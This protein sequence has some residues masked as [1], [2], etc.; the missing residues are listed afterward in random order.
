MSPMP[1]NSHATSRVLVA[2]YG[3][4]IAAAAFAVAVVV[5]IHRLH[6]TLGE[7]LD[8]VELEYRETQK[9]TTLALHVQRFAQESAEA[10]V[11]STDI[12]DRL[13]QAQA[14][15][16]VLRDIVQK[17]EDAVRT[18][19]DEQAKQEA[20][21]A[22][23]IAEAFHAFVQQVDELARIGRDAPG[24]QAKLNA[25]FDEIL[26]GKL[27]K[28]MDKAM[29]TEWEDEDRKVV[30]YRDTATKLTWGV[31]ILLIILI[32]L[33]VTPLY[34]RLERGVRRLIEGAR[35][36]AAGDYA[37]RVEVR[38]MF[39][40]ISDSFNGLAQRIQE[41]RLAQVKMAKELQA[42][43]AE[44]LAV[45]KQ[46]ETNAADEAAAV[47]ETRRTMS[48]LLA[49]AT[50]IA[51]SADTVASKAES[52]TRA[53]EGIGEQIMKLSLQS[54]KIRKITTA[55][56]GIADKSDILALNASLEG[57]KAGDAG[58]GFVLLGSEMR[59]LAE[60]VNNAAHEV[61]DLASEIEEL[62]KSA[63]MSTEVGQRF[64][65]ETLEVAQR[66]TLITSQQ[67]GATEQVSKNME[68]VHQY[69]Q[70]SLSAAKQTRS[71]ASDL[72]RT[73]D[74]LEKLVNSQSAARPPQESA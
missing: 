6:S 57:A 63:V 39:R 11:R 3:V 18:Q 30:D 19:G 36:V 27:L 38:G 65:A 32:G 55:I 12:A 41:H 43:S 31:S 44:L 20:R 67:R 45:A 50:L 72:V 2:S 66:I 35:K 64:A 24:F 74:D 21:E 62:S 22:A 51:E 52:S 9:H 7:S 49:S 15:R 70:H 71:T 10:L 54:Q 56:Q 14:A 68:D 61:A 73:S 5:V 48:A 8:R 46:T 26:R 40:Q 59:R 28:A 1:D 33:I 34:L 53:S 69:T 37:A 47:E 58:R 25:T 29:E 16:K 17:T 60:S 23:E 13:G 42:S 4:L